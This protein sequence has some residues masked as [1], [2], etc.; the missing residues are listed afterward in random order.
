MHSGP[1]PARSNI[2]NKPSRDITKAV[3]NYYADGIADRANPGWSLSLTA[4]GDVSSSAAS[5]QQSLHYSE[6]LDQFPAYRWLVGCAR[7]IL[8]LDTP[9]ENAIPDIAWT[10]P[11]ES[12]LRKADITWSLT[13][14]DVD[15][16]L[17]WDPRLF[18]RVQ[19]YAGNPAN[20]FD[21]IITLTGSLDNAQALTCAQYMRQTWPESSDCVISLLHQLLEAR[22]NCSSSGPCDC[23]SNQGAFD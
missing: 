17:D 16:I 3:H 19:E 21:H 23:S 1:T 20:I 5:G 22:E 15:F 11:I 4:S 14:R 8:T 6:L 12:L 13:L 7:K 18:L 2:D 10:F 9:G